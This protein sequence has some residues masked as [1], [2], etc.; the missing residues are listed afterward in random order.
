MLDTF[1][2]SQA[3]KNIEIKK[4][5]ELDLDFILST[6]NSAEN[7]P[8][9]NT[10]SIDR[11]R[12]AMGNEDIYYGVVFSDSHKVGFV[13]L[14][15]L[16]NENHSIEFLRVVI[17][18]KGKG[19]GRQVLKWAKEAAFKDRRPFNRRTLISLPTIWN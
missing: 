8:F 15:G 19:I 2:Y 10:W 7:T 18:E 12:A 17:R 6:E 11:H 9:I 16:K 3:M 4:A 13:I 1:R 14:A 5:Q